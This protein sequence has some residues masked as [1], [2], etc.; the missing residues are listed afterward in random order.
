LLGAL[1]VGVVDTMGRFLLPQMLALFVPP[2]QAGLIGGAAASMLIYVMLALILAMK[3]RGLFPAAHARGRHADP[4][5]Y[6]QPDPGCAAACS[7]APGQCVRPAVLRHAR[8]PCRYP[9]AGGDRP[10]P[11]AWARRPGILRP[12]GLLRDWRLCGRH[13]GNPCLL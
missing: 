12:C 3:P 7:A 8:N 2:S 10:Q 4:A 9:G 13:P 11:R 1:L 5:S 6:R